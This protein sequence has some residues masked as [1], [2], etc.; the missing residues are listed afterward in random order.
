M[1]SGESKPAT[2]FKKRL[3]HR[4]FPVNFAKFLR[5]PFPTEHIWRMLLYQKRISNAIR[6]LWWTLFCK[7]SKQLKTVYKFYIHFILD[8]WQRLK[9]SST[10]FYR[11]SR[12]EVFLGKGVVKIC[13]KFTGE[14]PRR[15]GISINL[16]SRFIEIALHHGCSPVNLLYIFRTP[17]PKNTSGWPLLFLNVFIADFSKGFF[18]PR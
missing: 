14:D 6:H 9:Y 4:C 3:W 18:L 16:Q 12:P 15:T 1:F 7:N 13:S 10:C 8:V 5:I 11:S 17:F 2:L